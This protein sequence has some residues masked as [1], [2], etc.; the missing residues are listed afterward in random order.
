VRGDSERK[1]PWGDNW[2][3]DKY[4]ATELLKRK[5][6][7]FVVGSFPAGASKQGLVDLAGNVWEWTRSTY[8]AYPGYEKK[9]FEFG[10]GSKVRQVN[11]LAAFDDQARVVVGGSFQTRNLMCRATTRV[12]VGEKL[13]TD[14]IGLRCARSVRPGVDAAQLLL[15]LELTDFWRPRV[16]EQPVAYEPAGATALE[17]WRLAPLLELP[18]QPLVPGYAVIAGHD[19]IVWCPVKPLHASDP[20]TFRELCSDEGVVQLGFLATSVG[21]SDPEL[22]PGLYLVSYRQKGVP[23]FLS[24]LDPQKRAGRP[25][26][27]GAPLEELLKIDIRFDHVIFSDLHG[28]PLRAVRRSVEFGTYKDARVEVVE[29]EGKPVARLGAA[30]GSRTAQKGFLLELDLVAEPGA[31]DGE[32]RGDARPR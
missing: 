13:A 20:G 3:N 31:L 27:E 23:R 2:D 4:A 26:P 24:T 28:T 21:L 7:P 8:S 17:R 16:V 10:Y 25:A 19:E 32:W 18:G 9:F 11:A 12:A 22:A 6:G 1:Y 29:V 5:G 30:I 15:E 14:A